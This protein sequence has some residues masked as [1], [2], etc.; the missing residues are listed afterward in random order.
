MWLQGRPG[1]MAALYAAHNARVSVAVS[2]SLGIR[3][4]S[5][6]WR[7]RQGIAIGDG[8]DAR[9]DVNVLPQPRSQPLLAACCYID[10][11]ECSWSEYVA[12]DLEDAHH[13]PVSWMSRA[14]SCPISKLDSSMAWRTK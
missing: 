7:G 8:Y 4:R 14:R 2:T 6:Q 5:V 1:R 9:G 3:G 13:L 10:V 11:V 12:D